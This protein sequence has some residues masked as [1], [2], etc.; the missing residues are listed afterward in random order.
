[1]RTASAVKPT[2]ARVVHTAPGRLRVRIDSPRGQGRLRQLANVLQ[3]MPET[4]AVRPNHA[5]R[6]VTVTY[7][8]RIVSPT[9]L[10]DRLQEVCSLAFNLVDP[11][12]WPE[13]LVE[14]VVPRAEDPSTLAGQLNR[15]LLEA[16]LGK[17]DLFRVAVGLLLLS[18]GFQVRGSFVRGEP[19]PWLRVVTYLLAAA[20]IWTRHRD[21]GNLTVVGVAGRSGQ[22]AV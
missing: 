15:Q 18:V 8:P 19:V 2:H 1:M 13:A 17:L 22:P 3:E 21:E 16:T 14:D 10:L 9:T 20:S 6:S 11:L 7:N 4:E 5:A 12:E